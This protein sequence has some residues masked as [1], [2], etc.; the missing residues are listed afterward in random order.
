MV[1]VQEGARGG[2]FAVPVLDVAD[3]ALAFLDR[4][5]YRGGAVREV[6]RPLLLKYW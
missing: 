3:A 2:H 4:L 5:A 6:G 1:L